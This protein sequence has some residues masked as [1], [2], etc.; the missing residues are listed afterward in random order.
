MTPNHDF[1]TVRTLIARNAAL[2][3]QKTAM[4]EF[5]TGR[6]CTFDDLLE[7]AKRIGSALHGMGVKKG[8]RVGI[9]SQ[10]SYEYM[11]LILSVTAAGYVFVPVNFRLAGREMGESSPMP[12]PWCSSSRNST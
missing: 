6:S 9:M 12:S 8:E 3:P 2:Y 1:Q 11:E 5:E 10:N 7:R 4:K